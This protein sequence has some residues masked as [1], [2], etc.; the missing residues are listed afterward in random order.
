M[1]SK[2]QKLIHYCYDLLARRRYS[3]HEMVTKLEAR[4][5]KSAEPSTEEELKQIL[6]ALAKANLL[7]D[8]DY[9]SFY[10]DSQLRRKPVGPLKI[11][12]QLR[13]RG[14][15]EEIIVQTLNTAQLDS[16][17]LA[18]QLL[19]KKIKP[20]SLD[21]LADKKNQARLLRY[22]AGNGFSASIAFKAIRELVSHRSQL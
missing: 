19:S 7:N 11:K 18:K 14:I 3:I 17:E 8:R 20:C 6:E 4:N 9:A 13:K 2:Q 16:F 12:M 10:L 1:N 15:D 22:L 21:Q 5:H